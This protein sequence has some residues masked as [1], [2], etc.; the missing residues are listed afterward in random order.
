M[1]TAG[2]PGTVKATPLLHVPF[3]R[4]R[5]IPVTEPG[6]TEAT[7]CVSFQLTTWPAALPSTTVLPVAVN[8]KPE[9]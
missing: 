1:V 2:L 9:P 3:F 4:I 5:A 7:T 6:A 8:P